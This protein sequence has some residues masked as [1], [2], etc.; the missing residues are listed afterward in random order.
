MNT[1]RVRIFAGPNGSG[2]T[3]LA[4][5]LSEHYALNL[6]RF[7]NADVIYA[8][9]VK[10]HRT[11]CPFPM[12][13]AALM[14]FVEKATF[15]Q[16][17][18]EWF[19]KGLVRIE[20]DF[21]VFDATAVNSYTVALLADFYRSECVA[22][23]ESFSF[24]TVFSHPSKVSFLKKARE[25]GYRTYMYFVAT[26]A[27]SINVSRIGSRVL[28]GGHDVPME[29]VIER[30]SRSLDNAAAALAYLNRAYFF[31]N[32]GVSIR[33]LAELNDGE[34]HLRTSNP[35]QWFDRHI[36]KSPNAE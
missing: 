36:L 30:Y 7:I 29:K 5:W 14:Q 33:F 4:G 31:D 16:R 28:N 10:S 23:K 24:E 17:E 2:K 27:P 21:V 9:V 34:W 35:P 26:D 20:N 6:Y 18:K 11:A 1:L 25:S 3:T 19:L 32:S 12:E 13:H 15:P 22:R 8:E